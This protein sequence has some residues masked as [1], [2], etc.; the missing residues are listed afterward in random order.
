M[1]DIKEDLLR[2][3]VRVSKSITKLQTWFYSAEE[4]LKVEIADIVF[5][6]LNDIVLGVGEGGVIGLVMKNGDR[7]IYKREDE[8][9]ESTIREN[10]NNWMQIE[11]IAFIPRLPEGVIT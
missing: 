1:N 2:Y 9:W 7:N 4:D 6:L 10:F 3:T 8:D 5:S 11:M